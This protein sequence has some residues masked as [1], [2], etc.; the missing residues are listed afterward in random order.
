MIINIPG[1]GDLMDVSYK[2]KILDA[3]LL[4]VS[5]AP[6]AEVLIRRADEKFECT[7]VH[8]GIEWVV[9]PTKEME[10]FD[11]EQADR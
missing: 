2:G 9:I 5:R 10:D 11:R 3:I 7:I 8:N 4:K 6:I 1:V